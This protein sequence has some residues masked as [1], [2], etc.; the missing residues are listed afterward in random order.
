MDETIVGV[1]SLN[2]SKFNAVK[3]AFSKFFKQI[4]IKKIRVESQVSNQPIGME[5]IL[6]GAKNR[7]KA[8]LHSLLIDNDEKE[9]LF[10]V[11]IEAGLV[12]IPHALS[13]YMDFQFCAIMDNKHRVSLGSGIAF[14][15]PQSV[16]NTILKDQNTEIGEIMGKL[17]G[18]LNLKNETGAISYLSKNALTRTEILTQ[19]VICALLPII[20]RELYKR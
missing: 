14:E 12:K 10:G 5:N 13:G 2:P 1:G 19:A 3:I 9:N 17:S 8:A 6:T 15:Y 7:A 4:E 16:I 18:N 20:N 11:G